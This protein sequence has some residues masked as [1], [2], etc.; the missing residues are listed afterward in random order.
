[1]ALE[2]DEKLAVGVRSIDEQH[3]ELFRRVNALLAALGKGTGRQ[4]VG[5]L[6]EFLRRYTVQHF[7]M[8]EEL[9]GRRRYPEFAAHKAQH[10]QFVKTFAALRA[11]FEASGPSMSF[12]LTVNSLVCAW[13]R[14]HIATT[15]KALGRFVAELKRTRAAT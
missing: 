6:L 11:E 10:D 8:E 7:G 4:A 13:L 12:T 15:D 1:M 3:Q 2:W 5:E 14:Q 9:M